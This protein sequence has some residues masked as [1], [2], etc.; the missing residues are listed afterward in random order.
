VRA[1]EAA[2]VAPY[3]S[4]VT[5]PG[6]F[7]GDLAIVLRGRDFRRLFAVRLVSQT[8]DGVLQVGLAAYVFFS[9]ERQTTATAAAAAFATLLLPFTIVGPFAGVLLDRW[10]RRQILLW[11]NAARTVLV[12]ILAALVAGAVGGPQFYVL[13]L[14][15][16]S[17]NRFFL[18]CL[19]AS[20][21]HVVPED[22]LVMANA[23]SPT[24]GTLAAM[25]GAG[26]GFVIRDL[27]G[28]NAAILVTASVWYAAAAA[29]AVRIK[30]PALLGPDVAVE[31]HLRHAVADVAHGL[32][33]AA[34]HVW[35]RR[36]AARALG[37]IAG[38][39]F[40]YGIATISLVLLFRNYFN[41]PAD[42]DAGV[43]GLA[44]AVT[45]SAVGFFVAAAVTPITTRRL[46]TTGWMV[47]LLVLG[48][49]AQLFPASLFTVPAILFTVLVLGFV[50]QGL[51][52][53]VD[54]TVQQYVDDE[55]RG[56]VFAFYDVV[57]N[58]S[59]IAA[60]VVAALV[61]PPSGKSY[62]VLFSV[63]FGYLVIAWLFRRSSTRAP[64]HEPT[65]LVVEPRQ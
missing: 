10:Q 61:M 9:P 8:G 1:G 35:Q 31:A 54:T 26:L 46:G 41:D 27:A 32:I 34:H 22:E 49:A 51:K 42:V 12:L 37:V 47:A 53:C 63:A 19:G 5:G 28:G 65:Q 2:R 7:F 57:F 33:G 4:D 11:A 20:L 45:A 58:A 52:I 14:V 59:F 56:R 48:A 24:S 62:V 3:A 25:A 38:N 43:A 44:A 21:P 18:A 60:A 55:F 17:V 40:G 29:L 50:A 6:H 36:P 13:A 16:L 64:S 39:R 23:V 30:P 15:T